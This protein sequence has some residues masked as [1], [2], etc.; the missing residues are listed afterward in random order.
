MK[1]VFAIY[2]RYANPSHPGFGDNDSMWI[3]HSTHQ[4]SFIADTSKNTIKEIKKYAMSWIY[5]NFISNKKEW[6][7]V[8]EKKF[9]VF[10]K[11]MMKESKE[12]ALINF[13]NRVYDDWDCVIGWHI[14]SVQNEEIVD[15]DNFG[16]DGY[17]K[18]VSIKSIDVEDFVAPEG[19][20]DSICL[21]D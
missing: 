9:N 10:F 8:T 17:C 6:V 11:R 21:T 18:Y 19:Y 20:Y 16:D 5:N 13:R 14:R 3:S 15:I 1:K 7:D 2:L 12:K 4:A